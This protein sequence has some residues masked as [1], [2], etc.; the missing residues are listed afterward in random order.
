MVSNYT[1]SLQDPEGLLY[2]QSPSHTRSTSPNPSFVLIGLLLLA[3]LHVLVHRV[4]LSE[5]F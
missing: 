1:L 4:Y 3:R 2:H 5:M